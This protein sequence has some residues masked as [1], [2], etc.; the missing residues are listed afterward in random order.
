MIPARTAT[1]DILWPVKT[2][3]DGTVAPEA[4]PRHGIEHHYAPLA[5]IRFEAT[6]ARCDDCRRIIEPFAT[7]PAVRRAKRAR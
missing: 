3:P 5:R 2:K 1:G 6:G 4:L 7:A